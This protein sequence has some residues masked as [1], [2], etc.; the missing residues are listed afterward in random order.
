[1]P[2]KHPTLQDGPR[3]D[4]RLYPPGDKRSTSICLNGHKLSLV[5]SIEVRMDS[6]DNI[7][8]VRLEV[9]PSEIRV[10]G[11]TGAFDYYHAP[12]PLERELCALL[13]PH[14][15]ETGESEGAADVLKRVLKNYN[16]RRK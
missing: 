14:V 8:Y 13:S 10:N 3:F 15:G 7:P 4:L 1:M 12:T 6:K 5:K 16:A 11:K 2:K 9:I